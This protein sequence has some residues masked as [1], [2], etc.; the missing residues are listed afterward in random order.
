[1]GNERAV[2][3]EEFQVRVQSGKFKVQSFLSSD[4]QWNITLK[5]FD[6]LVLTF[7]LST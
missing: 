6:L 7:A 1:L 3:K 5:T 4:F 2:V